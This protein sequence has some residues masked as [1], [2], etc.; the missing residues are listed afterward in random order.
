MKAYIPALLKSEE[1]DETVPPRLRTLPYALQ[2]SHVADQTRNTS[3]GGI[4]SSTLYLGNCSIASFFAPEA[5]DAGIERHV[6]FRILSEFFCAS[7]LGLGLHEP[8]LL[9]I[10]HHHQTPVLLQLDHEHPAGVIRH[11]SSV[12]IA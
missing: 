8:L 5:E 11:F 4:E 3:F 9:K 1:A 2:M 12:D 6:Y 7:R 10:P